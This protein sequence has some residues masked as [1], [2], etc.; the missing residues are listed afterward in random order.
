MEDDGL[1]SAHRCGAEALRV[2]SEDPIMAAALFRAAARY[3]EKGR[4][5][6]RLDGRASL[7][8]VGSGPVQ[9]GWE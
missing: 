9:G 2:L 4:D 7:R 8:A 1:Q 3:A 6:R 5:A